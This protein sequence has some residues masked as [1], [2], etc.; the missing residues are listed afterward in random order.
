[1]KK[2][3]NIGKSG[4]QYQ[5][6][7]PNRVSCART[8]S[9]RLSEPTIISTVTITKP[10]DTSYETIC[11]ADR[12]AARNGYFEFDAHPAMITP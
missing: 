1:M 7:R 6:K 12:R 3:T 8:T 5:P 2:I 4:S 9:F 10:M 11:A